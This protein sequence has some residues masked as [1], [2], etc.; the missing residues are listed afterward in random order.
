MSM[1]TRF[2]TLGAATIISCL[3]ISLGMQQ[4]R[5]AKQLTN[6]VNRRMIELS[7]WMEGEEIL[8]YHGVKVS[9]AEVLNFYKRFFCGFVPAD[10]EMQLVQNGCEISMKNGAYL[11]E[12]Q[13]SKSL[14]YCPDN[15]VYQCN[16]V[17]NQ[18][19]VITA[20]RF[21]MQES[22]E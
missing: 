12:L 15:A 4:Y 22:L 7:A 19:R 16:V 1:A 2:L 14:L 17:E 20:V 9:G 5:Q 21:V 18:N 11:A 3:L 13:N 10:F 6:I 8:Q